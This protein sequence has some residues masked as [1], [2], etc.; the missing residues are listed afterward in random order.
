MTLVRPSRRSFSIAALVALIA[1][2]C[3]SYAQ[4]QVYPSRPLRMIVPFSPGGATDIIARTLSEPMSQALGQPILIINRDGAGTI[5]GVNEAA[6]AATDGYT[7]L[8]SG[9]A[10]VINTASGRKLPYDLLKDLAPI[11]IVYTG[12]Q[13]LLANKSGKFATLQDLVK[14]GKANPGQVKFGTTGVGTAIHMSSEIFNQA[15]GIKALH[16][17][18]KGLAPAMTDLAGG[19]VDY[20]IGGT[21]AAIPAVK[22]GQFRGL[23]LMSKAR[24][25][26]APDIPTAIEQGVNAETGAWYGIYMRAGTPADALK[27]IHATLMKVLASSEVKERFKSLGAETRSMSPQEFAAYTRDEIRKLG[28]LMKQLNV[29]LED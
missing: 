23:A 19:H 8:L 17:P 14:Y 4:A 20:V 22:S 28:A 7:L 16:V 26:Q 3:L 6:H 27:K 24:T 21:T 2:P 25:D 11:S 9:D 29:K 12:A 15:A 18:Y 13:V 1:L 10:G 5:I